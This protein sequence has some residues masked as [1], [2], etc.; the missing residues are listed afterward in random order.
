MHLLRAHVP[1]PHV[2]IQYHP[3]GAR[4]LATRVF[5]PTQRWD[6]PFKINTVP[7]KPTMATLMT[8]DELSLHFGSTVNKND[9]ETSEVA[10]HRHKLQP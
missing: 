7:F 4:N 8:P 5:S 9:T 6:T 3:T 1:L 10:K 2:K